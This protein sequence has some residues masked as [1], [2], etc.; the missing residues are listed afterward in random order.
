MVKK[1]TVI[2]LGAGTI[3]QIPL[4][5][6]R[7]LTSNQ[8]ALYVRTADHPVLEE[9]KQDGVVFQSFDSFYE[10]H[11]QFED[12]Y[13]EIV[14]FLI[15]AAANSPIVYAVPGHPMLAERTVKLLLQLEEKDSDLQINMS[16]G[17]S[18]L[19]SLFQALKVDPIEGFQF[20]DASSFSRFDLQYSQHIIF[21]QVYDERI[22]SEVKLALLE[23]LPFDYEITIVD[24]AGTDQ[25]RI[26]KVALYELDRKVKISNLMS[27]YVPPVN[28]E[29]LNHQFNRLREVIATLRGPGG[30]PWDQKQTHKTLKPYLIEEAYEVIE[31]IDDEND[32]LLAD[33]LGD[34]LLQIMLHSQIGEE[35]GYFTVDDVI[36]HITD[37]MIRRHPHVFG[38]TT[39]QT[40][41]ELS[42]QWASIKQEEKGNQDAE[43]SQLD[44]IEKSLPNLMYAYELQ[45]KA[46]KVGFDWEDV[47][48]MWEKVHEEMQE[49][50]EAIQNNKANEAEAELGDILFAIVNI[51]RYYKIHPE[52]ALFQTNR[53]FKARFQYMEKTAK[54]QGLQ[55][56]DMSLQQMDKLWSEAKKLEEKRG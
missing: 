36:K 51:A 54:Q 45:K 19:D 34:V 30:C 33:E 9:L 55:L 3:E 18:Y 2:G 28:K 20:V 44:G 29:L 6:Y 25:E 42:K 11:E 1:I 39:V 10:K 17:Q 12:V 35:A 40:E 38:D 32:E 15:E 43:H 53:K 8:D 16:G 14:S 27:V 52:M 37:K 4:G 24:A 49:F 13:E 46:A 22:A 41:A 23:D 50:K 7:L 26:E 48:P 21:S 47:S 5:V 56:N 31:A